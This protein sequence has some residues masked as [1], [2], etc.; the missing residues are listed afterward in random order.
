MIPF[1]IREMTGEDIP[2]VQLFLTQHLNEFF[3]ADRP[4]PSAGEDVFHL[5][6]QYIQQERNLLLCAWSDKHELIATLAVCQ[7]DDR[8]AE[9][10]GRYILTE[11]AE[12]CRCYVDKR[13]R[14]QGIGRQL[15]AFAET[16]CEQQQYTLL[17]LH[18]H[19]FLPG[20]YSFWKRNDFQVVM[21]MHDDWQLVHMERSHKLS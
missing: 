14:R 10:R 11:T 19:H 12:I 7:Y 20:G 3:A 17:Y 4:V 13:F 8:I 16:F 21:D 15:L 18:T 9:L 6:Q 5:R 2:A 1:T